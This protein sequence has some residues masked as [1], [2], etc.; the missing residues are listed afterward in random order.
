MVQAVGNDVRTVAPPRESEGTYDYYVFGMCSFGGRKCSPSEKDHFDKASLYTHIHHTLYHLK[1][2]YLFIYLY[3]TL[4]LIC[5][6][7]ATRQF[8]SKLIAYKESAVLL[9]R[10]LLLQNISKGPFRA[11]NEFFTEQILYT[12]FFDFLPKFFVRCCKMPKLPKSVII[13]VRKT[14]FLN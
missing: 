10:I 8:A 4:L 1:Y 2:F 5:Q 13:Q 3:Q 7:L 14:R 6:T 12:Q 9:F 11:K